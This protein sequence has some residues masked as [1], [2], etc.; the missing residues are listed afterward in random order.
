MSSRNSTRARPEAAALVV[1]MDADVKHVALAD[2]DRQD[3]MADDAVRTF[4]DM[5]DITHAQ[6][7]AEMASVQE[8]RRPPPRLRARRADLPRTWPAAAARRRNHR[9]HGAPARFWPAPDPPRPCAFPS[10]CAADRPDGRSR[11]A[12]CRDSSAAGR[13]GASG[14]SVLSKLCAACRPSAT[15]SLGFIC[16]IWRMR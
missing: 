13:A 12:A 4:V 8:I 3:T 2:R 14:T 1:R 6:A 10:G 15:M 16:S 11:S 7:V 9:A 5:A